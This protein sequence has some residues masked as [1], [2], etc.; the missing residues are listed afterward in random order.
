MM[1]LSKSVF[2]SPPAR[3]TMRRCWRGCGCTVSDPLLTQNAKKAGR[4]G[5]KQ[6]KIRRANG[7]KKHKSEPKRLRFVRE[8]TYGPEGRGFESLT[9]CHPETV[10]TQRLRGFLLSP[11]AAKTGGD[12]KPN[13][14]LSSAAVTQALSSSVRGAASAPMRCCRQVPVAAGTLIG[15]KRAHFAP[16]YFLRSY[17]KRNT[18]LAIIEK[19]REVRAC[20]RESWKRARPWCR[21][22]RASASGQACSIRMR[23]K[24]P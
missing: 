11:Y 20:I 24:Y 14:C 22:C 2:L 23:T 7:G 8:T 1:K 16:V 6:W 4:A 17:L 18:N 15:F 10:A 3:W 5:R 9:A 13:F 21:F 12:A 19:T